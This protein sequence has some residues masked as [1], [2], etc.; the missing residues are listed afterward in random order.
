MDLESNNSKATASTDLN[1]RE[2][3]EW[4][5]VRNGERD[6]VRWGVE[7]CIV[8]EPSDQMEGGDGEKLREIENEN[9]M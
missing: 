1:M 6:M 5:V 7:L 2:R 3:N 9:L 8:C 4:E